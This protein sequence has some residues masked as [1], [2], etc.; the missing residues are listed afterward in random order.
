MDLTIL[1]AAKEALIAKQALAGIMPVDIQKYYIPFDEVLAIFTETASLL[2]ELNER[3]VTAEA[4]I[5][6]RMLCTKYKAD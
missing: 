1:N 4:N 6:N 2:T 3:L 5:A